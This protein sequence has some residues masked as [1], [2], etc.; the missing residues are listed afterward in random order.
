MALPAPPVPSSIKSGCAQ[1]LGRALICPCLPTL[2]QTGAQGPAPQGAV[3]C[4]HGC[5]QVWSCQAQ[6]C[7][8]WRLPVWLPALYRQRLP[9]SLPSSCLKLGGRTHPCCPS[10]GE[11]SN[12]RSNNPSTLPTACG[13]GRM[14]NS[15]S[16]SVGRCLR[17]SAN[18]KGGDMVALGRDKRGC[19]VG[20][21][22][23]G[24][25]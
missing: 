22:G 23:F 24:V 17:E 6:P 11:L 14:E 7:F 12:L 5:F 8:G 18:H 4:G 10:Q 3:R 16:P 20:E 2:A 19:G 13:G 25:G 9:S 21:L 1:E 15:H